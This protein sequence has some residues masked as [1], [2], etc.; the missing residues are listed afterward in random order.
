MIKVAYVSIGGSA[1]S[2]PPPVKE[3]QPQDD[4]YWQQGESDEEKMEIELDAEVDTAAPLRAYAS[5]PA[6]P[7]M[8]GSKSSESSA[9]PSFPPDTTAAESTQQSACDIAAHLA[10]ELGSGEGL[11]SGGE[12][13]SVVPQVEGN[14]QGVRRGCCIVL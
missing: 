2:S 10:T 11:S 1:V 4:A 5:E 7:M 6:S 9:P 14:T 12:E 8:A 13:V 3:Y